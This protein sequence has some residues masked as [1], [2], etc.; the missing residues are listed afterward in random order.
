M[1]VYVINLDRHPD[2]LAHM[3]EQLAE[4]TFERVGAVDGTKYPETTKGLTR[5]ESGGSASHLS[6]AQEEALKAWIAATLPRSTRQVGA[7]MSR[8]SASSMRAARG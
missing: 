1:K 4:I 8:S 6:Q 2:R 3:R 7:Y 5:F